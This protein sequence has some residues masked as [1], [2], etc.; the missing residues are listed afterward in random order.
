MQATQRSDSYSPAARDRRRTPTPPRTS[1]QLRGQA[2]AETNAGDSP[3]RMVAVALPRRQQDR[4]PPSSG[5]DHWSPAE[6]LT[7][8]ALRK[9]LSATTAAPCINWATSNTLRD[10]RF[11]PIGRVKPGHRVGDHAAAPGCE[12][13]AIAMPRSV[14]GGRFPAPK[15]SAAAPHPPSTPHIS[16]A[17][18]RTSDPKP[19]SAC[20]PAGS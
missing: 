16:Y 17:T 15:P 3:S 8:A 2:F 11:R 5:A 12:L 14:S 6:L 18:D 19:R 13:P 9:E 7:A 4:S 1:S 20:T 10:E